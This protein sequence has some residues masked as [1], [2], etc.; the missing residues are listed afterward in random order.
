MMVLKCQTSV[1]VTII[2]PARSE[3][4]PRKLGP[5]ANEY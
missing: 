1:A 2:I 3:W 4:Q 5:H